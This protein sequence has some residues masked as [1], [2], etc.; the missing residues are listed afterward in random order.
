MRRLSGECAGPGALPSLAGVS[1][2]AGTLLWDAHTAGAETGFLRAERLAAQDTRGVGLST[3]R[4]GAPPEGDGERSRFSCGVGLGKA[5]VWEHGGRLACAG[6]R[7]AV[8]SPESLSS[9]F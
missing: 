3:L 9:T 4:S 5:K 1:S 2:S 6:R 8:Q 7:R